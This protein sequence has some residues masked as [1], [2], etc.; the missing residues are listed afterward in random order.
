MDLRGAFQ[1]PRGPQAV[2][3]GVAESA[4]ARKYPNLDLG[5]IARLEVLR[6]AR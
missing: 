6:Q 3:Q 1:V 4:E 5:P 2:R